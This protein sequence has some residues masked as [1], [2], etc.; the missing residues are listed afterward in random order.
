V[1]GTSFDYNPNVNPY[2]NYPFG[3][4][5]VWNVDNLCNESSNSEGTG[6][7]G[8]AWCA[9]TG[10][11]GGGNSQYWGRPFYQ[12]GPGIQNRYTTYAGESIPNGVTQCS[13]AHPGTP[14][15]ETPDIS[16]DADEW[17]GY[18][19]YCTGSAATPY[20]TCATFSGGEPAPGWFQI[21]GTSLSSP[22]WSAIIGDRVSF[23]GHRV[24]NAN[25]LLY[26]LYNTNAN[27]FFNDITGFGQ[28][29]N[30]NGLFPVTPG[31]DLA[32]GIGSPKMGALITNFPQL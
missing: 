25:P 23:Q 9:N 20:S 15:R 24:G 26:W 5:T 18:A 16:A 22:L 7:P 31:Y 17:T 3:K 11:G 29:T 14:C 19:E 27:G 32:T 1:G 8:A 10:A 13:L 12:F 30:N 2:P 6:V 4:E 21:G 28:A